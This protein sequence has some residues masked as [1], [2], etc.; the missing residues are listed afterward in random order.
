M[1][2]KNLAVFGLYP[3]P[4]VAGEGMDA[5]KRIGFRNTDVSILL[6]DNVGSK[7]IGHEKNTK[8]LEGAATGTLAGA[9]LGAAVAWLLAAGVLHVV[10]A[11]RLMAAGPLVSTLGG[12]GVGGLL[13]WL[14]GAIAG[15]A[16][17][18]YEAKRYEGRIKEGGS[19]LSVHCDNSDW[20]GRAKRVLEQTGAHDVSSAGEASADYAETDKPRPRGG[21]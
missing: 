9:A 15:F 21:Y 16:I 18:E 14:S 7:D 19:L 3:D 1:A 5:L 20:V 8:A 10:W 2:T 13:G 17:P 12:A 6:P 11:D 4:I